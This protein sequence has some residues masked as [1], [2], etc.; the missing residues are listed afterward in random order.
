[1]IVFNAQ[2][3]AAVVIQAGK[4]AGTFGEDPEKELLPTVQR[5]LR[6]QTWSQLA[7]ASHGNY[8]PWFVLR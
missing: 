6:D 8:L 1:M 2:F 4:V 7:M 3:L 5:L